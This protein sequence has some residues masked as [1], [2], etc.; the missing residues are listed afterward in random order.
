VPYR[1]LSD[2]QRL[3]L[4]EVAAWV[5]QYACVKRAFIFGSAS[6][7]DDSEGDLD[8]AVEYDASIYDKTAGAGLLEDFAELQASGERWALELEAKLGRPVVLHGMFPHEPCDAAWPSVVEA[9]AHP[10]SSKGKAILIAVP[11]SRTQT[12]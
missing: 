5:D 4:D 10:I 7:G 11:P 9:S 8:V 12:G 3:V 2:F 1:H 6:S